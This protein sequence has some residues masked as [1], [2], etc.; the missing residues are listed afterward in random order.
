[1]RSHQ[2]LFVLDTTEFMY[3]KSRRIG[4]E[5]GQYSIPPT[6]YPLSRSTSICLMLLLIR[7]VNWAVQSENGSADHR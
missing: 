2:L 1:M 3:R 4:T 6:T 5:Y 7:H